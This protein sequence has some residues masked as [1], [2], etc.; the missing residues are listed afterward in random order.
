MSRN[1]GLPGPPPPPINKMSHGPPGF[2]AGSRQNMLMSTSYDAYDDEDDYDTLADL[3]SYHSF[4]SIQKRMNQ[5]S[6]STSLPVLTSTSKPKDCEINLFPKTYLRGSKLTISSQ[7][8][9]TVSDLSL[10]S[11]DDRLKSL[12]VKGPCCWEIFA[13]KNFLG[14][15]KQFNT[16][17][18][19]SSTMIGADL[20]REASSLK[21]SV[22]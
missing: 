11:F 5:Y 1:I 10:Y 17:E 13:D 2:Y 12:E 22:C 6:T 20:V 15:R 19:K 8:N 21:I 4:P 14:N 18:Y 9:S 16:G 3:T 7:S